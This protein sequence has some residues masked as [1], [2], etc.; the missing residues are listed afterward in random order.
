MGVIALWEVQVWGHGHAV[1]VV[2][3]L[4]CVGHVV[5]R[6]LGWIHRWHSRLVLVTRLFDLYVLFAGLFLCTLA[7]AS[8]GGWVRWFL[9][10]VIPVLFVCLLLNLYLRVV[11]G[12][13]E[14]L[15][16][17]HVLSG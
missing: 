17:L 16:T 10:E 6:G 2:A 12:P 14:E 1:V 5:V 15:P 13:F 9:E 11:P 8:L 4:S 7:R 3:L